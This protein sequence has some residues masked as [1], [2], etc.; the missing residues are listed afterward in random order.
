MDKIYFYDT[1]IRNML[2]DNLKHLNLRIDTGNLWENFI[3]AERRKQ[4]LYQ[5]L[6]VQSWF[7]RN[8]SG[9]EIDYVEEDENG[10]TAYEIKMEKNNARIPKAWKEDY[11]SDFRL[12]NRSNY[13][14][15]ILKGM[16]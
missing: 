7:W 9:A 2:I 1:G 6:N 15:F 12:I 8:Y 13:L 3:V 5:R 16:R 4:I 11:G 10:L 14:D